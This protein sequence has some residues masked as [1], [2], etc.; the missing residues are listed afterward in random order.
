M[1]P[2]CGWSAVGCIHSIGSGGW[3]WGWE[4]VATP[5]PIAAAAAADIVL[6]PPPDNVDKL[7]KSAIKMKKIHWGREGKNVRRDRNT[8][9]INKTKDEAENSG[10]AGIVYEY[11]MGR[12]ESESL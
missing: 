3:E 12:T 2:W 6:L 4:G 5:A 8:N 7:D 9:V 10:L 1:S 11:C